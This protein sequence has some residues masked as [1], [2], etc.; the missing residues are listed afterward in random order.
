MTRLTQLLHLDDGEF[1][2][3]RAAI[4]AKPTAAPPARKPL[5]WGRAMLDH[6]AEEAPVA[7]RTLVMFRPAA[8]QPIVLTDWSA[9]IARDFG[10][11]DS[12]LTLWAQQTRQA[13]HDLNIAAYNEYRA[14]DVLCGM[15]GSLINDVRGW[16]REVA[17]WNTM[18]P[19]LAP[20]ADAVKAGASL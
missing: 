11:V 13:V 9:R 8:P 4:E 2:E 7:P 17:D 1:V 3:A 19:E 15:I 18:V 12:A 14:Y 6:L 16:R 20:F 5:G 10:C